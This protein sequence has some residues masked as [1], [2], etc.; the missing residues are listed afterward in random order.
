MNPSYDKYYQTE[1]LFGQPYPELISFFEHLPAK[2]KV[3]DLGCGQGRDAIS[4]ARLGF[5]VRGLDNSEVG[6]EQMLQVADKE[7]LSLTGS[8]ED[9]F[10]FEN[11]AE[12]DFVV[13]DSMFHFQKGDKA[14]EI[15]FVEK[16]LAGVREG[17]QV[18]FCIQDSGKKVEILNG[19]LNSFIKLERVAT[20]SFDYR[21]E[22]RE[23]EH[24]S[25][26]KYQMLVVRK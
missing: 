14:R 8:V 7:E 3:L 4:L 13:L 12:Y 15:A 19:V 22:D 9:I 23:S 24:H 10:A 6:I 20:E 18:V 1:D 25:E 11:F 5:E 26:M 21:Y 2:G 17:C 16:I